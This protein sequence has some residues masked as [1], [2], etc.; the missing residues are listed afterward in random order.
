[1][2]TPEY[3]DMA[4]DAI[5]ELYSQLDETI[6][7]DIVRRL[8]K[9][10]G[11]TPTAA[12]QAAR[13]QDAGLL[14][15]DIIRKVSSMTDASAAQVKALFQD[16]GIEALK[17]DSAI[18]KAAGLFPLPLSQSP[19]A[20]QVLQA[21]LQKTQGYLKNLSLTTAATSQT[22]YINAVTLAEM[23]AES[24]AFDYITAI[25]NAVRNAAQVGTTVL[26]PTGHVDKL[27]VAVRRA[28]LT[29]ISQTAAQISVRYADD[30][31][32]DLVETTAHPGARPSHAI[33]Q[34]RVFSRS[35]NHKKYPDFVRSTGYGSGDGLCGW[36]CRHSFFPFFEGLSESAYPRA[37]LAEYKNKA[38]TYNDQ[39]VGYYDATQM[40]RS[41]ERQIRATKR[42]LAG[43][44]EGVKS[45]DE[46]IR[47]AMQN[48]F[49]QASLKLKRQEA[50]LKD[51]TQQTGLYR[52]REREQVL[53]FGRSPAQKSV[54]VQRKIE[55][56]PPS[57]FS[58][59][60]AD[61]K[62]TDENYANALKKRFDSGSDT[63]KSVFSK[64]V[65][66]GSVANGALSGTAHYSRLT[67]RVYMNFAEDAANVRGAGA[68]YFHEHG[69]LVDFAS[70]IPV[71]NSKNFKVALQNDFDS[72]ILNYK[73]NHAISSHSDAYSAISADLCKS[74]VYSSVSDIMGAFTGNKIK[75][76]WG[77]RAAYWSDPDN[78]TA[79]SF[80]HLFEAQFSEERLKA[81]STYFPTAT[82][83]FEKLLEGLL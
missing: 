63:A 2:L 3:L 56:Q 7:R 81:F 77:H 4:P 55:G 64:Y 21:G 52:Q 60:L 34:G 38:V 6:I 50:E 16:A 59:S 72:Y 28:T 75:G 23:Q 36:N 44:D 43:Y 33:W 11:V 82:A 53:G 46:K 18:Y 8:V 19:A 79:E 5:I 58:K 35:G 66:D 22:A 65:P 39:K 24:G 15:D 47:N 29:G 37:K 73:Q 26:Y 30:M 41:M 42:E 31:G 74:N 78:V 32:C 20:A 57:A 48:D 25:R 76:G 13:L 68:T 61:N 17:Y 80:A 49:N 71:S 69:H 67:K 70:G 9:T 83:E 45:D 51:F 1:M 40:Q 14:Y 12:W 27:D 10:G 62:I 54:W